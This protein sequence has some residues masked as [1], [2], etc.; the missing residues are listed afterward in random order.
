MEDLPLTETSVTVGGMNEPSMTPAERVG[1]NVRVA[2]RWQSIRHNT[3]ADALGMS[4]AAMSRRLSGETPFS[5][6]E[7]VVIAGMVG[8]T[9]GD[10][11]DR[12]PWTPPTEP[13]K[14]D[15]PALVEPAA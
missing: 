14:E 11:V 2:L 1:R 9:V 10:L 13:R 5:V 6:V 3:A 8:L 12:D 15:T 4:T 7:M